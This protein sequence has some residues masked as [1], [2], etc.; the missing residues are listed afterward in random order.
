MDLSQCLVLLV[1]PQQQGSERCPSQCQ[2][3]APT[4][5]G[6]IRKQPMIAITINPVANILI[7][8]FLLLLPATVVLLFIWH[9]MCFLFVNIRCSEFVA[10]CIFLSTFLITR[11]R[12]QFNQT[13][14]QRYLSEP[15][16]FFYFCFNFC[17]QTYI[18]THA[19]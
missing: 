11:W 16:S 14:T 19:S 5:L 9:Y 15:S 2:L 3:T 12:Q 18:S 17:P 13:Y 1:F 10:N 7:F 4:L 8:F 6:Q